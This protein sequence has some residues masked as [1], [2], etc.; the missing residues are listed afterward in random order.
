MGCV[1]GDDTQCGDLAARDLEIDSA[2]I[3][4]LH[5]VK[6]LMYDKSPMRHEWSMG[7]MGDHDGMVVSFHEGVSRV[8]L[9]S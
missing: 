7:N 6:A 1:H 9:V 5:S 3:L 8:L 4:L 2:L